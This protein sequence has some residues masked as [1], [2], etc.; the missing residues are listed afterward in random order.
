M[1]KPTQNKIIIVAD[2]MDSPL[3]KQQE[4]KTK[5]HIYVTVLKYNNFY[6]LHYIFII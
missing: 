3:A 4:L 1:L 5:H 6:L 2:L